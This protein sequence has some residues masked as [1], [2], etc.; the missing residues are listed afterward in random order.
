MW[1]RNGTRGALEIRQKF[2]A[3]ILVVCIRVRERTIDETS[4]CVRGNPIR[5]SSINTWGILSALRSPSRNSDISRSC[6]IGCDDLSNYK[7]YVSGVMRS[8][9]KR[10]IN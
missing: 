1:V 3:S 9:I 5:R 10:V 7:Y 6:L 8:V 2:R 4:D